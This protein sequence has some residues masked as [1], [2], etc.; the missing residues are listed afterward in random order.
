MASTGAGSAPLIGAGRTATAV[1]AFSASVAPLPY[2]GTTLAAASSTGA[3]LT[4][5][6]GT[7]RTAAT[8]L[9][10]NLMVGGGAT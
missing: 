2:A 5:L 3:G 1:A 8:G 10:L 9:L 6:A 7:G 4:P